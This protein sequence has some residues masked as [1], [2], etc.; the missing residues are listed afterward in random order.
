MTALHIGPRGLA[1]CAVASILLLCSDAGVASAGPAAWQLQL[2][3]GSEYDTNI[4]HTEVFEGDEGDEGDIEAAP[5]SRFGGR[6]R[7][8][9]T[10][11]SG[12]L[13]V[14]AFA[15]SKLFVTESG[16]SE[17]V[18]ILSGS[19]RYDRA[20]GDSRAL[21]GFSGAAYD[22][23]GY[24]PF[25]EEQPARGRN[26]SLL[27]GSGILTL[28]GPGDH[29]VSATVG[30]RDFRYKRNHD[31]S[32]AGDHYGVHYRT[33]L[34]R[35]DEEVLEPSSID[36]SAG[37]RVERRAFEGVAF[38]RDGDAQAPPVSSRIPRADLHHVVG[39]EVVFTGES[40]Y[41]GRYDVEIND[42]NSYGGHSYIRQRLE[43]G[44]TTELPAKLYL[45]AKGV[46]RFNIF[47]DPLLVAR[48]R[49]IQS[50]SFVT[51]DEE[52]RNSLT[53]HLSRDLSDEWSIET[54][55]GIYS[56]E[57][58]TEEFKFRRQVFY[59]GAVWALSNSPDSGA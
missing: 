17:N 47:R 38:R 37:Y 24:Q 40:I 6:F 9:D 44:M 53:L 18:G 57:F 29:R 46:V 34:W 11:S 20:L 58:A 41:S 36:I 27:S 7:M 51:I 3:A 31:Y 1:C 32:W 15:G 25:G 33:V 28:R 10:E 48:S 5:V 45:T 19:L 35:S 54:R 59:L 39:G 14:E 12:R 55:Y 4:H 49:D 50:Q 8:A 42:S 43:L 21:V 56:N 2:E 22:A 26:F 13:S 30:Y 23:F 16:Q 52:N